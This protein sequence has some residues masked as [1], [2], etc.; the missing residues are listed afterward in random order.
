MKCARSTI[1]ALWH[2]SRCVVCIL[3]DLSAEH[4]YLADT[5]HRKLRRDVPKSRRS[6]RL[7]DLGNCYDKKRCLAFH[8]LKRKRWL[9]CKKKGLIQKQLYLIL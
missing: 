1:T 7:L 4:G 8:S 5:E 3:K 9:I 2:C 6:L